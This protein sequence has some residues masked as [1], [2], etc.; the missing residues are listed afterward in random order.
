MSEAE[1]IAAAVVSALESNRK[2]TPET[3]EIHHDYVD[4]L[5]IRDKKR[6]DMYDQIKLHVVKYGAL[7]VLG[8]IGIACWHYFQEMI[9]SGVPPQ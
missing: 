7:G 5:I 8:A 1:K 9:K 4:T 3:H 6:A 2:L